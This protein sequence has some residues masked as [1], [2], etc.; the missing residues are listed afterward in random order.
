MTTEEQALQILSVFKTICKKY[1]VWFTVEKE[2][3]PNLRMIKIK[4]ISIKV[5]K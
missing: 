1:G 3:K 2:Y 4:E 5:G